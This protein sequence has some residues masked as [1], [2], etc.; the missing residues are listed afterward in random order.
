MTRLDESTLVAYADERL[1]EAET[2]A[3]RA[4]LAADPVA[5]EA[6]ARLRATPNR[7]R[8]VFDTTLRRPLPPELAAGLLSQP[9]AHAPEARVR[10]R[11][12]LA[13]TVVLFAIGLSLGYR[14]NEETAG[15]EAWVT[16]VA[17]YQMLYSRDTVPAADLTPAQV[18]ALEAAFSARLNAPLRV[19]DLRAFDLF[20][21]RGQLLEWQGAPLVQW[22]YLPPQGKP[23]AYCLRRAPGADRAPKAGMVKDV[24]Y[25]HGQ[26]QG[27][28]YVMVG[29]ADP[30]LLD[31]LTREALVSMPSATMRGSP[32]L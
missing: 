15:S 14:L 28:A 30:A 7:L 26:Q 32:A 22:V 2:Q 12:V 13:A 1:R 19:P 8:D 4:Q 3:V 10:L 21:K 20:F 17:D 18:R 25:V 9:V 5:R 23:I 16:A 24:H 31:R 6:L 27:L 29:Q 11:Y